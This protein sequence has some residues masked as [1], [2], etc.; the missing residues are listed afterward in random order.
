MLDIGMIVSGAVVALVVV[1]ADRWRGD[2]SDHD[3]SVLDR[4]YMPLLGGVVV[5]RLIALALDDPTSLGAIRSILVIRGGVEFWPGVAAFAALVAWSGRRRGTA[6]VRHACE[7]APFAMWGYAT[8]EATCVFRDG[9]FGPSS[10]VG[11][12]PPGL[13]DRQFPIGIAMG[14]AVAALGGMILRRSGV[15][16]GTSLLA[17]VAS[18][19]LVR[20]IGSV[21]LPHLGDGFT[22]QHIQSVGVLVAAGLVAG[23]GHRLG[24]WPGGLVSERLADLAP[25]DDE[26]GP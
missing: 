3:M 22:R 9:C 14:L 23:V 4:L 13:A 17:A 19:A 24:R 8:Y 5:G 16:P 12:V 1:L 6:A 20:S 11:L 7:L 10:P 21:W 25:L 26:P 2:T 18:V 15:D